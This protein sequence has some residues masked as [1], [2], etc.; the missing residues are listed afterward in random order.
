M[1]ASKPKGTKA[2]RG[3]LP[4]AQLRNDGAAP[5][6]STRLADVDLDVV[7]VTYKKTNDQ[8]LR[9]ILIEHNSVWNTG[10]RSGTGG[11]R[12]DHPSAPGVVIRDNIAWGGRSYGI[13]GDVG[14][15]ISGRNLCPEAELC[16]V[17]SAPQFVNPPSDFRLK[18]TSPAIGALIVWVCSSSM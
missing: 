14:T 2:T 10:E 3:K 8:N 4:A 7:W 16:N 1:G 12:V 17:T 15:T 5:R 11:I 13:R 18:S 6:R 9:N